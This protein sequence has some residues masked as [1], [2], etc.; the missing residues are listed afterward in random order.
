MKLKDITFFAIPLIIVAIIILATMG[1][2]EDK[3]TSHKLMLQARELEEVTLYYTRKPHKI[4]QSYKDDPSINTLFKYLQLE[5]VQLNH[6]VSQHAF[7][8]N[9]L[10]KSGQ[11]FSVSVEKVTGN[12]KSNPRFFL[13][14]GNSNGTVYKA[15]ELGKFFEREVENLKLKH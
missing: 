12:K 9:I 3:Q 7:S 6:P 13:R 5:R 15:N 14:I 4:V 8:L 10:T 11:R 2:H 1:N